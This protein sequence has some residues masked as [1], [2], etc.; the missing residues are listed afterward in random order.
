ISDLCNAGAA[1]LAR[2]RQIK[3]N[4]RIISL[5]AFLESEVRNELRSK[6]AS[7]NGSAE[8][9]TGD[10]TRVPDRAPETKTTRLSGRVDYR[11]SDLE[12]YCYLVRTMKSV[13]EPVSGPRP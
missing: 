12:R 5:L 13:P 2:L 9:I 6:N 10:W 4:P 8:R 3:N 11:D 1:A 7:P